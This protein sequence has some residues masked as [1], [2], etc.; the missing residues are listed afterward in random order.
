MSGLR[1]FGTIYPRAEKW[2]PPERCGRRLHKVDHESVHRSDSS[3]R[4]KHYPKP[5]QL[6]G[7]TGSQPYLAPA[8]VM[9]FAPCCTHC[10]D[11]R[12]TGQVSPQGISGR[13]TGMRGAGP[14]TPLPRDGWQNSRGCEQ[15]AARGYVGTAGSYNRPTVS[16]LQ[17]LR[18]QGRGKL[19]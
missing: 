6:A 3:L 10:R 4:Q 8:T 18:C 11:L 7:L 1:N 9:L 17:T 12:L 16:A 2:T 19:G 5:I 13:T 14:L 15:P